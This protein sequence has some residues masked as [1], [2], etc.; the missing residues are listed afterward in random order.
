MNS[1]KIKKIKIKFIINGLILWW[2]RIY[3]VMHIVWNGN[4]NNFRIDRIKNLRKEK[5]IKKKKIKNIVIFI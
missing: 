5:M 4:K 3:K 2:C 1:K